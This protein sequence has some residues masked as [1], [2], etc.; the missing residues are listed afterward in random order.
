MS[1]ESLP[2][3]SF[4]DAYVDFAHPNFKSSLKDLE[5][6]SQEASELIKDDFNLIDLVRVYEKGFDLISSLNAFCRCKMSENTKDLRVAIASSE[7]GKFDIKFK[8]IKEIL[9]KNLLLLNDDDIFW[10]NADVDH[11]KIMC[12]NHK[13][14]YDSKLESVEKKIFMKLEDSNFTPLYGHFQKLNNF[15]N[16]PAENSNGDSNFYGLAKCIGILKGSSDS[17]LRKNIFIGLNE[18]Y[19]EFAPLY[20]DI[21]NYL[22]GFRLQKIA[23]TNVDFRLPSFEQNKISIQSI[24]AMY[25]ALQIRIE[26]IRELVSLRSKYFNKSSLSACDLL[27]PSPISENESISFDKS[28]NIVKDALNSVSSEMGDF[29]DFMLEKKYFEA[30][31]RKNKAGGAFYTR[32]NA[33]KQPRVF[34]TFT[35]TFSS[36]VQQAHELGHAWHYW[37]MKDMP[38]LKTEF[39]M[40]LTEIASTFNEAI[41]RDYL[42]RT[43]TNKKLLFDILWQEIKAAANFMLHISVRYDFE[44]SFIKARQNGPVTK[45][46]VEEF[47]LSAWRKWYGSSTD[48][49]EQFLPYFK[50]HFYKTDQYIYNYPYT[51]GYL[52]SQFLISQF[53]KTDNFMDK[54]KAFLRD[55]GVLTVEEI[56]KKHFNKDTRS[57]DFWL[58]C[59]DSCLSYAK[60]F[61]QIEK[62]LKF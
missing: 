62:E 45:E 35:G 33:L 23:Y 59:C 27:A 43:A 24:E 52:I 47:M 51:I 15:I 61:K 17:V 2:A 10:K 28:I 21:L 9:F 54:Y 53:S 32:F 34:T 4:D 42:K 7:V 18:H 38:S 40:S 39:P 19:R 16:I 60:E 30:K 5:Y 58:E 36:M 56:L 55:S 49:I 1:T 48:D 50:L 31:V 44:I 14:S 26:E 41:L 57:I 3:W 8:A 6:L 22:H 25:S 37:I 46:Q 12:R 20:I 11:Y 13:S 29:V